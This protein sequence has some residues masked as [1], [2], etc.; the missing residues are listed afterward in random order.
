MMILFEQAEEEGRVIEV[1]SFDVHLDR[2]EG[3]DEGATGEGGDANSEGGDDKGPA[4]YTAE[5]KEQINKSLKMLLCRP[6]RRLVLVTY[7][8]V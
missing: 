4:K 2:E 1:E 7:Q 8:A 5:E 6:Q 3:D